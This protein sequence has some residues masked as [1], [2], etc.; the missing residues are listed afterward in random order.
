[1]ASG[2]P[3]GGDVDGT[4]KIVTT[5]GEP[6]AVASCSFDPGYD[7]E[8]TFEGGDARNRFTK[9]DLLRGFSTDDH[10]TGEER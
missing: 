7:L 10:I 5:M 3:Q 1:V 8:E 6:L 9:A 4:T 2:R